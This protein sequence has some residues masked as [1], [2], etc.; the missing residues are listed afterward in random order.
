MEKSQQNQLAALSSQQL[1][2]S[3]NT[4]TTNPFSTLP[5]I[6]PQMTMTPEQLQQMYSMLYGQ[7]KLD[8]NG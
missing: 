5:A 2:D 8:L 4:G 6:N 3:L 7:K 1:L